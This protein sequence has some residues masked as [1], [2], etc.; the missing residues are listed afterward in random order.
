VT[1]AKFCLGWL[2]VGMAETNNSSC[3][4]SPI[5]FN[6]LDDL[7]KKDP[8]LAD[9]LR[10]RY[11]PRYINP[12]QPESAGGIKTSWTV[13]EL[14]NTE[15]EDP[16]WAVPGIF[17]AGLTMLGAKPKLGKSWLALQLAHSKGTGGRFFNI[18]LEKGSVLYLALEDSPRRLQDRLKKQHAP[19]NAAVTFEFE[20]KISSMGGLADLQN[21]I[22]AGDY[23]LVIIDTLS[24]FLGGR[25]DQKDP[26]EVTD[27]LGSL[28]HF[29]V[30]HNIAIIIIDHHRK[31]N[32]I[33]TGDPIEDLLGSMAKGGVSDCS[34]GLY[35][36]RGKHGATMKLTG[37][38]VAERELSLE[39]DGALFCW[40]YQGEAQAVRED[41]E[42]GRVLASAIALFEDGETPTTS[43][44]SNST[45]ID[46]GNVSKCLAD[47]VGCGLLVKADKKDG[48]QQPYIPPTSKG[49]IQ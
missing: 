14:L 26:G 15:F 49:G 39:W 10:Q 22:I 6:Q 48:R 17:P 30:T 34:I 45:G 42:K 7:A 40:Q 2:G 37:R 18:Q 20:W 44:I 25:I 12:E 16:N 36:E 29:A 31:P 38:D 46:V 28:Q 24:R 23:K 19:D 3:P 33:A 32:G 43:K 1:F 4:L 9:L 27:A 8:V 5:D 35:R 41:S 11:Y 21:A 13:S 47:L